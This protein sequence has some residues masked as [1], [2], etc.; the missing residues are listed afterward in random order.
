MNG[1]ALIAVGIICFTL[2]LVA[3][4]W[5]ADRSEHR[6]FLRELAAHAQPDQHEQIRRQ[7]GLS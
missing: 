6:V 4:M 7:A 5:K 3:G 2:L 1:T